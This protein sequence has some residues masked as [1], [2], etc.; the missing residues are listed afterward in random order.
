[1][2]VLLAALGA[3]L[4]C[5][6]SSL[7]AVGPLP[8]SAGPN[9]ATA[10]PSLAAAP[11]LGP[12]RS[13]DPYTYASPSPTESGFFGGSLAVQ[14]STVVVGAMGENVSGK[15]GAGAVYLF[16]ATTGGLLRTLTSP[17]AQIDGGFGAAVAISGKV[18]VVGAPEENVTGEAAAGRAY[19][20]STSGTLLATLTSPSPEKSGCFGA[21]VAVSKSTV[22]VGAPC[23]TVSAQ[24]DA[25]QVYLFRLP[26][27]LLH[28]LAS[29]DALYYGKD[30]RSYF[31]SAVAL[32]GSTLVVGAPFEDA[33]SAKAAGHVYVYKATTGELLAT[34]T[35][36]NAVAQGQFGASVAASGKTVLVGAPGETV[37]TFK[38][39]GHAYVYDLATGIFAETFSSPNAAYNS[40]FG[41][42][43]GISK[44]T[45]LIGAWNETANGDEGAGHAYTF[46][47][48]GVLLTTLVSP[49]AQTGGEFGESVAI[50]G[51]TVL[52]GAPGETVSAVLM[53][54]HAY[55]S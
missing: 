37:S 17:N 31:G 41:V 45:V 54:G 52:V 30:T 27:T 20:F 51:K 49:G 1:V 39:A 29:P 42:S 33:P 38:Y 8:S 2:G 14:G 50:S 6:A 28:T 16:R 36:P 5:T 25:G 24:V 18:V 19:V 43:V 22:V 53:A 46:T 4:P 21:A 10:L 11:L 26:G 7:P 34:L 12:S 40:S 35:S 15:F 55:Q 9:G 48:A 23:E 32:S 44:S 47:T 3:A 13:H